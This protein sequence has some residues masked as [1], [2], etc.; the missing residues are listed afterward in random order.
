MKMKLQARKTAL[1][2]KQVHIATHFQLELAVTAVTQL[3]HLPCE[4]F[5]RQL[6]SP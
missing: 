3:I 2:Q 5:G 4:L 6:N 1:R